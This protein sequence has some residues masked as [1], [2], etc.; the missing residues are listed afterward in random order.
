MSNFKEPKRFWSKVNVGEVGECWD[1]LAQTDGW[2][3]GRFQIHD[4]PW[5]AHRV[6]WILT[7]GPIP[8][9]LGV[10]HHCDNPGCCNPYHLFLG[11]PADNVADAVRKGR[12]R[13]PKGERN[14]KSKL[15][16]DNVLDIRE[17]HDTG[18][19][20]QREIAE[21]FDVSR[22]AIRG[23]VNRRTWKHI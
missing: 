11:T 3:Y 9:G 21:E 18:E 16:E 20:T 1:W 19:W 13:G 15:T 23:V 8:E 17:L 7:Y 6:A 10:L 5:Q 14:P 2:D 22:G 4:K 12:Q